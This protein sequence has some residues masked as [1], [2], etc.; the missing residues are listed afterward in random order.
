MIIFDKDHTLVLPASGEVWVQNPT[1]Q[2]P[3]IPIATIAALT[4]EHDLYIASNQEG[5]CR[6]T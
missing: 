3:L 1:D 6:W 4:R 2:A 5:C